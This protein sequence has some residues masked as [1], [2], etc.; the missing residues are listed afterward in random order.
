MTSYAA[1]W[2]KRK[3]QMS[4]L[5]SVIMPVY[6]VSAYLSEAIE[7]V[8]AQSYADFEFIIVD[9]G[10]TDSSLDICQKFAIM[11]SRVKVYS[12]KNG[13]LSSARNHGIA[14]ASGDYLFFID[15]DDM[16]TPD[17]LERLYG[18]LAQS[19]ADVAVANHQKFFDKAKKMEGKGAVRFLSGKKYVRDIFG[20]RYIGAYAWGK[21]F[22]RYLFEDRLFPVG[23]LYEDML[24]I[25]YLLYDLKRIA[26]LDTPL[27]LY[28]QRQGS[29]LKTFSV[30]RVD[31]LYAIHDI[32]SFASK[33]SDYLL[34]WFARINEVR[35][36]CEL[37]SRYKKN[38]FDFSPVQDEMKKTVLKDLIGIFL[39]FYRS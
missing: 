6:N 19:G 3:V 33:R 31:E 16:I 14:R 34:L 15:S 21:L 2:A 22:P 20:P 1:A 26:Y 9:D 36:W 24:T 35:S 27:Y 11:D 10:S 17:C 28:R 30:N 7:S 37:K 8:L 12:K 39:P 13:G 29:I 18:A 4:K 25:P 38:G 32:V 23:R 5:I